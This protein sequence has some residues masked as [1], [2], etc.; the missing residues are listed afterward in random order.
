[1]QTRITRTLLFALAASLLL[2]SLSAKADSRNAYANASFSASFNGTITTSSDR[3]DDNTSTDTY[4]SSEQGTLDDMVI[5]R[6]T[7]QEMDVN[8][9]ST[10]S[11]FDQLAKGLN[12]S[13][14]NRTN[15]QW[16]GHPY[17]FGYLTYTSDNVKRAC[18][19]WVIVAN[20]KT[21]FLVSVDAPESDISIDEWTALSQSL[22]I[23]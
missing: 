12:A 2:A 22:S 17:T 8:Y 21:V 10:D 3:N 15:N 7:D 11:Y 14:A 13:I 20:S 4:Y 19:Q 18:Y 16:Q 1:M 9:T 6:T 5:V 23:K